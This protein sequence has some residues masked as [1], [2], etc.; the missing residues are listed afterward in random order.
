MRRT[1]HCRWRQLRWLEHGDNFKAVLVGQA[2]HSVNSVATANEIIDEHTT[3]PLTG[4]ALNVIAVA[5]LVGL[6]HLHNRQILG[7]CEHAAKP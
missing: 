3:E 1:R 4:L 2:A 6:A 7:H 5:G